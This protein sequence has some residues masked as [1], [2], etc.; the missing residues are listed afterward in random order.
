VHLTSYPNMTIRVALVAP[1][2]IP[3]PPQKYGGTEL[4]VAELALALQREGIEVVVYTNGESKL[5]LPLRW[6]YERAEWP[7]YGDLETNLKGLNHSSWA[8]S[9]A[10]TDTDIIHFNSA[11]GLVVSRFLEIP[12]VYTVHHPFDEKLTEFYQAFPEV[13]Y[14]TI[15][16]FQKQQL[17][18]PHIRAIHHGIDLSRYQLYDSKREHLTFLGRIAP[19]K[20]TH[21]AVDIAKKA[22]LPLKI[23]GEIQPIYKAYWEDVV[24]PQVDGRFIEYVGEVG[25]EEKNELLSTS[26][27][28]LFPVQW[29]E[30]FGLVMI[31]SMAC[32]TPVLALPGGSVEEV[33]LEGVSGHIRQTPA[34][35]AS[36]ARD[37]NIDPKIVRAYVEKCFSSKRMACD[38]INLYSELVDKKEGSEVEGLVA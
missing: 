9:E 37:L 34:E 23:A 15:S 36:C 20:G 8:A 27:A 16:R 1:P 5:N 25:M 13:S 26:R 14:V 35:L 6:I 24:K 11:P 28:M 17:N 22:G 32:G 3:V 2:F 38:Y 31:E 33:V 4:F 19:V 7:I 21:V 30:P 18:M 29:N 10:A 12:V